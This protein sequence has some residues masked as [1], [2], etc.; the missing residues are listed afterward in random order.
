MRNFVK[1]VA[2]LFAVAVFLL[3]SLAMGG[4]IAPVSAQQAPQIVTTQNSTLLYTPSMP[5]WNIF[6]PSSLIDAQATNDVPLM[7]YDRM[8]NIFLPGLAAGISEYPQNSSFILYLRKGL[9]WYNGS[10]A[11]PFSAWDVYAQFYIGAKVYSWYAPYLNASKIKVI[12]NYTI[13]FTL[14]TWAPTVPDL[15]LTSDIATPWYLWKSWV[16][17]LQAMNSTEA[18]AQGTAIEQYNQPPWFIGPYYVT[19]SPPYVVWHLD[20]Q[21]LLNAWATVFPYHTWQDYNPEFII[22]Y[23]GGNGQTMNA[24]LA[25]QVT[26]STVSFSASQIGVLKSAGQDVML[27]P[28]FW[29]PELTINPGLYPLNYTQVRLALE[30]AFNR[31]EACDA[32]NAPGVELVEPNYHILGFTLPYDDIPSWYNKML[33]NFTYN[34]QEAAQLLE[35]VGF[36]KKGGVWYA[37]NGQEFT[38]AIQTVAGW[39][40]EDDIIENVASQLTAF[41]IPTQVYAD[42]A[43]TLW[44]SIEPNGDFQLGL[45]G[46]IALANSFATAWQIGWWWAGIYPTSTANGWLPSKYYPITYPNGTKG[47][48]QMNQ[49]FT[50]L[51]S[52]VPLSAEY[53]QTM[54]QL[55]AFVDSQAPVIPIEAKMIPVQYNPK[56]FNLTWINSLPYTTQELWETVAMLPWPLNANM[57]QYYTIILGVT[58][59]GVNSP[60]EEAITTNSLSP[61]YDAFLG[62]SPS[63]SA[64]YSASAL[65]TSKI[66]LIASPTTMIAGTP[67]TLTATVT[68]A[69]GTPAAGVTVAFVASGAEIGSTV[70]GSNGQASFEYTPTQAGTQVIA[71]YLAYE[72][73]IKAPGITITVEKP[74]TI[75]P[76]K[77]YPTLSLSVSKSSVIQ[78]SPVVLTATATFPNGTPA[79]GYS[80]GFFANGGGIGTSTTGSNGQASFTYTPSAVGV[81]TL[82]ANLVSAPS[83][84]SNTVSLNVTAPSVTPTPT[85]P[86]SSN[87]TLYA[88]VTAVVVVIVVVAVVLALSRRGGKKGPQSQPQQQK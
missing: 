61:E 27:A 65:S 48:F 15:M 71:A 52:S 37:P 80:V 14:N 81:E 68:Y 7:Y 30:Y 85:T 12:N 4:F 28:A 55:A 47:T 40:A 21:N 69:N 73:T 56:V 62:L 24:I 31:T 87:T 17:K 22:W 3:S 16:T 1:K 64:R 72:P 67:T 53:N 29:G 5:V 25:G 66:S 49:W 6:N 19:V 41:G 8:N 45:I 34:P 84:T 76:T 50:K 86:S 63:Y 82:M 11:M 18:A 75:T 33:T 9:S 43:S 44:G 59:P 20:P 32:W 2:A 26:W 35:S 58:P 77:V 13:E 42:D 78:G 36:T 57:V 38:L 39:T 51:E 23:T 60:L 79:S 70:T 83:I 54:I 46:A 88:I 10:A 74:T